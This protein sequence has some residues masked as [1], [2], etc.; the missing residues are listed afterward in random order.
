MEVNKIRR[1]TPWGK[2]LFLYSSHGASTCAVCQQCLSIRL[3]DHIL[4]SSN[5]SE[6]FAIHSS[7]ESPLMWECVRAPA[8]CTPHP[9]W[10]GA[11]RKWQQHFIFSR[12]PVHTCLATLWC[13]RRVL[14]L[15]CG[16]PVG[17]LCIYLTFLTCSFPYR[18]L[19]W[20]RKCFVGSSGNYGGVSETIFS[21]S[22]TSGFALEAPYQLHSPSSP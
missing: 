15:S 9:H 18:G 12:R 14:K 13:C 19:L 5:Q 1:L 7:D 3:E 8:P 11:E 21:R 22:L 10:G 20:L 16:R 4:W 2:T 6:F 17:C